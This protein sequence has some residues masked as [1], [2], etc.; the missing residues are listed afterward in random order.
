M[1]LHKRIKRNAEEA[2]AKFHI[3]LNSTEHEIVT[4][5]SKYHNCEESYIRILYVLQEII[6][7]WVDGLIVDFQYEV[8]E[9]LRNDYQ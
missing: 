4:N 6:Q 9:N 3:T 1:Y 7:E 8:E 2:H 5:Q